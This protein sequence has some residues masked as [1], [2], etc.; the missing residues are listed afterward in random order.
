MRSSL[1]TVTAP[2]GERITTGESARTRCST[3]SGWRR[4]TETVDDGLSGLLTSQVF[5][6]E[7]RT[8]V[9]ASASRSV[10]GA[11]AWV[12]SGV[13][14]SVARRMT[15]QA[16]VCRQPESTKTRGALAPSRTSAKSGPVRTRS[17]LTAGGR[18]SGAASLIERISTDLLSRH[19][20]VGEGLVESDLRRPPELL[21]DE[22]GVSL[23]PRR[24]ERGLLVGV[25]HDRRRLTA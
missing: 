4:T 16:T 11:D 17:S 21:T 24:A 8:A 12:R 5:A 19:P 13:A 25:V 20:T 2:S 22:R 1:W 15:S 6:W 14:S 18:R 10:S 23:L 3:R 9:I 7:A